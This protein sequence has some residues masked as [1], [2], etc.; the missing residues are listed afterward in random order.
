MS[1]KGSLDIN[2]FVSFYFTINYIVYFINA[3]SKCDNALLIHIPISQYICFTESG[4]QLRNSK[5]IMTR[6]RMCQNYRF[7]KNKSFN[8]DLFVIVAEYP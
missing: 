4:L 7:Y 3:T 2:C 8:Y 5:Y 6:K 1:E